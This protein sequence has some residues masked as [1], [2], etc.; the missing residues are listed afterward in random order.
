M[1][2]FVKKYHAKDI[3]KKIDKNPSLATNLYIDSNKIEELLVLSYILKIFKLVIIIMNLS[4]L[5][6]V[7]WLVL[8]EAVYDF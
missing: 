3:M 1:M 6:G 2:N 4:Y 7:F 8:C 5:V